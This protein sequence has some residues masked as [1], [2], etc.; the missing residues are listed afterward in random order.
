MWVEAF[1]EYLRC[2]KNSSERT[3]DSYRRDLEELWTYIRATDE[4]VS[5]DNLD[6]DV[7]RQWVADRME[8]GYSARTVCRNLSALRSFY[9]FLLRRGLVSKSPVSGMQGPKKDKPLPQFVREAEMDCLLDGDYFPNS[10]E[11]I[12]DRLILLTFY[13]TG[14]RLSELLSL[15]WADIDLNAS[16]LKVTGKRDK[17]RIIPFGTELG[18]AFGEYRRC[19]EA[20]GVG[21]TSG[22]AVFQNIAKGTRISKSKVAETVR[23]YLSQVTTLKKRSPHVLR[24]S[25]ATSMLNNHADLQSVKELLGH[26]RITTTEI[27]TH[28]TFEE[29]K[30]MY[31]QAHP[32][33]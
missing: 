25:F 31:N 15:N 19:A 1:I 9:K 7:V 11:G 33:A 4:Q 13:T 30:E 29:M 16:T 17:Q 12:R 32:R 3:I 22:D 18:E 10:T 14:I 5:W 27:Y 8:R 28:T 21:T 24:H 26:E 23:H 6:K 20:E 2:E